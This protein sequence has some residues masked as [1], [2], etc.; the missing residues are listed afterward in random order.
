MQHM[1]SCPH[2]V[3][4]P[5]CYASNHHPFSLISFHYLPSS[6]TA[7]FPI[8][9]GNPSSIILC[10]CWLSWKNEIQVLLHWYLSF[11][12]LS[13]FTSSHQPFSLISFYYI[14]SSSPAY[15]LINEGNQASITPLTSPY[16]CSSPD[17]PLLPTPPNATPD[18]G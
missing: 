8:N 1:N 9:E 2:L 7:Y 5:L 6:T 4:E 15:F 3:R 10:G 16:L 14:L 11:Q 17:F 18:F 12:N 13:P